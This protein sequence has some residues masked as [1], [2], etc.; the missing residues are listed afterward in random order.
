MVDEQII[1]LPFADG[2][3]DVATLLGIAQHVDSNASSGKVVG[4]LGI[5]TITHG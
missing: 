2:I 1:D 4:Q 3:A 5:V